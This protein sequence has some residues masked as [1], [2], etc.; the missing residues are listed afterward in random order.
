MHLESPCPCGT[1][2]PSPGP[3]REHHYWDCPVAQAVIES[4]ET[5]LAP[6]PGF[7]MSHLWVPCAPH[8]VHGGVWQLVC[9]AAVAAMDAGRKRLYADSLPPTH[10]PLTLTAACGRYAAAKFWGFIADFTASSP[11]TPRCCSA[12]ARSPQTTPCCILI[13]LS[14]AS[15]SPVRL[16]P[17][18][19]RADPAC[20]YVAHA[21]LT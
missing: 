16:C 8:G 19:R 4:I 12:G 7:Q 13:P 10:T 18:A 2:D 14:S 6:R 5:A 17:P 11:S 9:L 1:S 15:L 21:D 3:G 20:S